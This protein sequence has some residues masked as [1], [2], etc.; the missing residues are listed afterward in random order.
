MNAIDTLI[1]V[2]Q[3]QENVSNVNTQQQASI[4]KFVWMA[5]MVNRGKPDFL[6]FIPFMHSIFCHIFK[7][8][9][10]KVIIFSVPI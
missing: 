7:I 9:L 4:A 10:S 2:W 3:K 1:Y 5:I 6:I 8:G